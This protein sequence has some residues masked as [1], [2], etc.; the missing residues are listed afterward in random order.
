MEPD[1]AGFAA[2][3]FHHAFQRGTDD[4]IAVQ[5]VGQ[6]RAHSVQTQQLPRACRHFAAQLRNIVLQAARRE[7]L[8][9]VKKQVTHAN[10]HEQ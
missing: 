5:G 9:P 10:R 3:R 2:H 4:L 8:A 6:S 1:G 7:L